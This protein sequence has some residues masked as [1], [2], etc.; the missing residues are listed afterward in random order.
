MGYY[1]NSLR[2]DIAF[3][4]NVA[5]VVILNSMSKFQ[6]NCTVSAS[7]FVEPNQQSLGIIHPHSD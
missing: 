1:S 4:F 5:A 3:F 7:N 2:R 6:E